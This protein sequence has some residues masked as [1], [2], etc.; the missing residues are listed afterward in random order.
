MDVLYATSDE[1]E[2]AVFAERRKPSQSPVSTTRASRPRPGE[3]SRRSLP[4]RNTP[5]SWR[6]TTSTKPRWTPQP[7]STRQLRSPASP[8]A[9][10]RRFPCFG[11]FES[12]LWVHDSTST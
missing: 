11:F 10:I 7:P 1:F 5:K 9:S 2:G 12:V 8:K 6:T 4:L 3:G